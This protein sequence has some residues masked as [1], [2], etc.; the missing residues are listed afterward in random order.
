MQSCPIHPYFGNKNFTLLQIKLWYSDLMSEHG[1]VIDALAA[2]CD[3]VQQVVMDF[4][5]DF[6]NGLIGRFLGMCEGIGSKAKELGGAVSKGISNLR[7][8]ETP[9]LAMVKAAPTHSIQQAIEP[10]RISAPSMEVQQA[11]SS[12]N[13]NFGSISGMQDMANEF[14]GHGCYASARGSGMGQ[15]M[16]RGL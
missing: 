4:A 5:D 8:P 6:M 10:S 14:S 12:A 15:S 3:K 13:L 9:A 11:L 7:A 1:Y 16:M 2:A